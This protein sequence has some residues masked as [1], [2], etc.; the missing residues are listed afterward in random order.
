MSS[1]AEDK[2]QNAQDETD[3]DFILEELERINTRSVDALLQHYRANPTE[4]GYT[5]EGP[6]GH[7]AN[8]TAAGHNRFVQIVDR[9]LA[10]S[11]F[12]RRR[13]SKESLIK[14]LEKEYLARAFDNSLSSTD[15]TGLFN[16]AVT[17][18]QTTHREIIHL[19]PCAVVAHRKTQR[20]SIGPVVFYWQE[21]FWKD[22]EPEIRKRLPDS[23]EIA[24]TFLSRIREFYGSYWWVAEV[25]VPPCNE[26]ISSVR[27]TRIVQKCLDLLKLRIGSGRAARI[28]QA[29][30]TALP[31]DQ[32][33]L[34]KID[35]LF[36]ISVGGGRMHDAVLNDD[37]FTQI[38]ADPMW[39]VAESVI[40]AYWNGWDQSGNEFQ[41][42][43]IDGMSWHSD[44][45]SDSD[46]TAQ[47]V[48]YWTAIERVASLKANDSFK[49]K[50]AILLSDTAEEYAE[51]TERVRRLYRQRSE[52]V[53]GSARRG[54]PEL[55]RCAR[56]SEEV[57][58]KILFRYLWLI[59]A[60]P[61]GV[62]PARAR[63]VIADLFA[64]WEHFLTGTPTRHGN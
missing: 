58:Q 61:A 59:R 14:Q 47:I 10:V 40:Q 11:D 62:D 56:E 48:K 41:Q 12:Q 5:L 2:E 30:D 46:I 50:A 36:H 49:K 20:F 24:E 55:E 35:D 1:V 18:V 27:A 17:S 38:S 57:S 28:H 53:H 34:R 15:P 16:A 54:D 8:F 21:S 64:Q 29:Y 23:P 39:K 51:A 6:D 45:V 63:A 52:I 22:A 19:I 31:H 13:F 9:R 26:N 43:F 44:A 32:S 42:R 7:T 37:W 60:A 25:C 33:H 3:Y 4:M